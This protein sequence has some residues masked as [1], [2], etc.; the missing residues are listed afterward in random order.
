L[1]GTHDEWA[2]QEVPAISDG[3]LGGGIHNTKTT[4]QPIY[5]KKTHKNNLQALH[6]IPLIPLLPAGKQPQITIL[7]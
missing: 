7:N 6:N 2:Y 4:L 3:A 5:R 1:F